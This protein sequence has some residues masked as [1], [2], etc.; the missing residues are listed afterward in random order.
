MPPALSWPTLES[1]SS[2]TLSWKSRKKKGRE[3]GISHTSAATICHENRCL[4]HDC[5]SKKWIFCSPFRTGTLIS[6]QHS[7][8]VCSGRST[9]HG[10]SASGTQLLNHTTRVVS[11]LLSGLSHSKEK[12][13]KCVHILF[14][15][16][17]REDEPPGPNHLFL[18]II[19]LKCKMNGEF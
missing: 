9:M 8:L 3:K 5:A 12:S 1:G 17:C 19:N 13:W 16:A 15:C 11:P 4:N 2:N 18:K 10:H 14:K 7:N 6:I